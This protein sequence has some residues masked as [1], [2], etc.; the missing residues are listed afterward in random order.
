MVLG[1]PGFGGFAQDFPLPAN[2]DLALG[3]FREERTARPF[4]DSFVDV[5][6]RVNGKGYVRRSGQI[7]GHTPTVT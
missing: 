5:G 3:Q 1:F 2:L 6:K 4:A 7:L